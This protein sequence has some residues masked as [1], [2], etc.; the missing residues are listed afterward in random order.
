[1]VMKRITAEPP[2]L[3]EY[4]KK[5]KQ[6]RALV[7]I[8]A[9]RDLK[10]KY[11]QTALGLSWT[12][13]QP[14]TGV[15]I[16]TVLF[17]TFMDMNTGNIPYMLFA[18]SGLINW[19][20]FIYIFNNINFSLVTSQEIIRK[21]YFPKLILPVSKTLVALLEYSLSFLLLLIVMAFMHF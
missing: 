18:F 11:A 14:L 7:Y 8:L 15:L 3:R 13:L 4:F 19:Y 10:A 12:F 20:L 5:F 1:M 2:T 21:I 9:K 16:F 17:G 6:Y